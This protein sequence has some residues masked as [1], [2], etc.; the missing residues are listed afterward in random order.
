M[1]NHAVSGK[2]DKNA[3]GFCLPV[4][5]AL[6]ATGALAISVCAFNLSGSAPET[7][8]AAASVARPGAGAAGNS[9]GLSAGTVAGTEA[10][11]FAAAGPPSDSLVAA[12]RTAAVLAAPQAEIAFPRPL[13]GSLGEDAPA[14][15]TVG[16]SGVGRP[17]AGY[18]MAPLKLLIPSSPFGFRVSPLSGLAGDFHLGQD[19]SAPCGTAV[20]AADSGVVRAAGWHPWGGGNRVEIDH[21]NG[22]VTTYNHLESIAVRSGDFVNVGQAIARVGT[23][24]WS[25]GC[26]LHFETILNGRHTNPLK[27]RLMAVRPLGAGPAELLTYLPVPSVASTGPIR[28]TIPV[29]LGSEAP[30]AAPWANVPTT[31]AGS[32]A[33]PA[34]SSLLVATVDT[35]TPSPTPTETGT[36]SPSPSPT[37]TG[38]P[39]L[40][41]IGTPSPTETG[42]P[43]PTE[44]APV[45]PAPTEPAP[46]EPAPVEPAPVEPAPVEPAPVEPAPVEPA[47]VEPAPVEP[48]PVEPAPV[49]PAPVEPAPVE[50]APTEPAP[51]EPAP[52]EPAPVE[53]APVEPAPTEPAP[54]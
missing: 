54:I 26:H 27:W 46:T 2:D 5:R 45:E 20:Y 29:G 36:P 52:T 39:S 28:W 6:A 19:Y 40:T 8:T 25:T 53:P 16:L 15:V 50:P 1:G 32:S 13:V 43:T 17:P 42:T 21:G 4:A 51:I 33:W 48:A 41:E 31:A 7:G 22:L 24:G 49:E 44:P 12:P 10:T 3:K 11:G 38:T 14:P 37:E 23:T 18:L 30:S 35:G 34:S 9:T 47:P